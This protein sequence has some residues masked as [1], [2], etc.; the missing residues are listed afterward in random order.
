MCLSGFT[1][2]YFHLDD[3]VSTPLGIKMALMLYVMYLTF[4]VLFYIVQ[5]VQGGEKKKATH[6]RLTKPCAPAGSKAT[7]LFPIDAVFVLIGQNPVSEWASGLG[8]ALNAK[9]EIAIDRLSRT[10]VGGLFAAGDVSDT[11]F[12]QAITGASE[13]VSAAYSAFTYLQKGKK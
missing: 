4:F 13:G 2:I 3:C 12:K 5:Y 11:E 8:V 7:E 9:G 6:L 10:N 1:Y